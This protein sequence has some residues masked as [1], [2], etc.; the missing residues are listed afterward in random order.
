MKTITKKQAQKWANALR[1][2]KYDQTVGTLQDE[3]GYCCLGVACKIFIPKTKLQVQSGF[4]KGALPM[5]QKKAP[6]WLKIINDNFVHYLGHELSD[7]NDNEGFNFD[8]I[9]DLIEL[10]Y[11]HKALDE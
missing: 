3:L 4:L 7:L 6:K 1:S 2:G 10:V 11:V 9:A 8:E 5:D